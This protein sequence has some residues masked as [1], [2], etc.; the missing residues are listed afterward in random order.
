M[1]F[2][3]M[4]ISTIIITITNNYNYYNDNE[5]DN[6]SDYDDDDK[7]TKDYC[8]VIRWSEDK[9]KAEKT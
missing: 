6:N 7:T 9:I 8:S 1:P 5:N 2:E 3:K 4:M